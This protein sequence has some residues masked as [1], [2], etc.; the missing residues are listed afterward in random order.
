[1]YMLLY[2]LFIRLSHFIKIKMSDQPV[3][4]EELTPLSKNYKQ[5]TFDDCMK[6]PQ[7]EETDQD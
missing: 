3:N 4:E 5:S 2:I 6:L 1:M 7:K